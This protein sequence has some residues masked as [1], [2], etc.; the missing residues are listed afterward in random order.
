MKYK[1]AH[2]ALTFVVL[3]G[4]VSLFADITY[5]GA[6]SITGQYLALLGASGTAVGVVVGF[7]EFIGYAFRVV[8]GYISDK[9]GRYWVMI[10]L[11]YAINLLAVPL[12][13]LTDHWPAA[14]ALIIM[15]RFGKSIR[16]PSRDALLSY[17]TKSM[18]RGWGFGLH[19][20]MDQIGAIL[21][22]LIVSCVLYFQGSYQM[23]FALLLIPALCALTVLIVS[24]RLYPRP[25]DLEINNPELKPEGFSKKYW[26]YIAAVCCVAAGYIDFPLIAYHIEKTQIFSKTWAPIFFSIAMAADGIA[27]LIFGRLYDKKGLSVLLFSTAISSLFV[28]FVF[29]DNFYAVLIGMILWGIGLGA[30]ESIMRAF[31]GQLVDMDKRGTAYGLMNMWFGISW[32]LG[33]ALLGYMYDTSLVAMIVFSLGIQLAS[34]PLYLMILKM[35]S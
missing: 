21:G 22:P 35:K 31:V 33:S 1:P 25:Q 26:L 23:S 28:L 19:E 3:M 17:A 8:T 29:V 30:Q 7:G 2:T 20:A 32:F 27:A 4:L 6:R 18:G 15:E 16:T 13:A 14:A 5:E 24:Q 12:L 11:G 10:F 34:L 9:T